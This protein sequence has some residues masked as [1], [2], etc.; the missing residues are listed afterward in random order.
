ME[1]GSFRAVKHD[2]VMVEYVIIHMLKPVKYTKTGVNPNMNYGLWL[3][4]VNIG[5]S[6]VTNVLHE[7]KVL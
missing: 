5:S 7:C 4:I 1:H 6:L 2:T 3:I